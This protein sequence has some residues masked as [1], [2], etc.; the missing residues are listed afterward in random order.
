MNIEQA[1]YLN[2]LS[3]IL[4]YT[5]FACIAKFRKLKD[6]WWKSSA[7]NTILKERRCVCMCVHVHVCVKVFL[8]DNA[9]LLRL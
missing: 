1:A 3:N 8:K 5:E 4:C 6:L 9:H 7:N 2:P